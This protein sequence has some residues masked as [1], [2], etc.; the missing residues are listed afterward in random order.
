MKGRHMRFGFL[1]S[2]FAIAAL[3]A[4]AQS[5]LGTGAISGTVQDASGGAVTDAQVT[6]TNVETGLVR[7]LVSGAGGQFTAP[8]LPPGTYKL[9]VTKPGFAA[10]EESDIVVNVGGTATLAAALKIG[11]VSET[12]TVEGGAAID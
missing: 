12:V 7:Q 8:V 2:I 4:L 1:L 11:G 5:Q 6:I 3:S 10:L 9:R